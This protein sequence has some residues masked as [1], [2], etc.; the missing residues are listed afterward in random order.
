[1]RICDFMQAIPSILL[2]IVISAALGTGYL[3]T[4]I[5][6]G[7]GR[8]PFA[9]RMIRAQFLKQ[10]NLEYV[11][12]AQMVNCSKARIMFRHILP[13]TIAPVIVSTT[14]GIGG[15]IIMGAS[16]SYIG[17]GVQPPVPEWGAMLSAARAF[18]RY[19]PYQLLF[20][21]LCIALFVLSLNLFGDG[22]RDAMDPKLKN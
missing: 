13:N 20:P 10:R 22:L 3:N 14:M 7:I 19:Y 2:A 6:L 18:M 9:I 8:T 5:A 15:T 16:L 1:M 4:I 11:E 12:A 21:G 17:L